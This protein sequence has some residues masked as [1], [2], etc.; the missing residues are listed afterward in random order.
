MVTSKHPNRISP[1]HSAISVGDPEQDAVYHV[2]I[3]C[4]HLGNIDPENMRWGRGYD[5]QGEAAAL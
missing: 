4:Y 2:C 5:H 1:Q 3:N